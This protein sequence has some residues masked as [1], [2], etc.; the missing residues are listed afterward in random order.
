M[1]KALPIKLFR[2]DPW[3]IKESL[4]LDIDAIFEGK[5]FTLGI[6]FGSLSGIRSGN[7]FGNPRLNGII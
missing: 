4:A 6:E 2:I 1:D 5:V 7:V 3:P